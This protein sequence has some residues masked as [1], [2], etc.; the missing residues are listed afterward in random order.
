MPHVGGCGARLPARVE[1]HRHQIGARDPVDHAVV[2]LGDERPA[3]VAQA[4]DH[5]H[6]PQRT[7]PVERLGHESSH[8]VPQVIGRAGRGQGR[9]ADVVVEPEVRIV[10]P[11]GPPEGGRDET[12]PLAVAGDERQLAA[13]QRHD[14]RIRGRR[15]L[16]HRAR[17]N[18]HVR[19]AV[20]DMEKRRI[21]RA[22]A[23]HL[24]CS[25]RMCGRE[26]PCTSRS[27]ARRT[28]TDQGH[29]PSISRRVAG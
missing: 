20:F 19:D 15:S 8:E 12:D 25:L 18:V 11:D 7:L 16:E 21:E 28:A 2:D 10:D 17:P 26:R 5:P 29:W 9:V 23:V 3:A 22:H 27:S 1:Q 14:L 24:F 6:L 4:F 13:E